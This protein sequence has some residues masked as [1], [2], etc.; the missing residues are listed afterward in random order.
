MTVVRMQILLP[1]SIAILDG[2]YEVYAA[3][4]IRTIRFSHPEYITYEA[5]P[6]KE[7]LECE[8]KSLAL[9]DFTTDVDISLIQNVMNEFARCANITLTTVNRLVAWYRIQTRRHYITELVLPQVEFALL[10]VVEPVRRDL[11]LYRYKELRPVNEILSNEEMEVLKQ[12]VS[13]LKP[14]PLEDLLLLDAEDALSQ[15]RYKEC[16]LICWS[17]IES[18]F[19]PLI[20]VKLK[21]RLPDI[22]FD[23]GQAGWNI[24]RDLWFFT[25]LDILPKLLADFSFK[26]LPDNFWNRLQSSRNIRNQVVHEGGDVEEDDAANTLAVTRDFV[27]AIK[28]F[29]E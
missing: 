5:E 15:H 19:D 21:E 13:N 17:A 24:E 20:R 9:M 16:V 22:G 11:R 7:I 28:D 29:R 26:E 6:V 4:R 25:R 18:I 23:I 2:E 8:G 14:P 3:R 12:N 27:N 1:Y 10:N